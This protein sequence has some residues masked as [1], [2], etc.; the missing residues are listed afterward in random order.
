[1]C[2]ERAP[3]SRECMAPP[4]QQAPRLATR[5]M[6]ER[7]GTG[8]QTSPSHSRQRVPQCPAAHSAQLQRLGPREA[9]YAPDRLGVLNAVCALTRRLHARP[10][11]RRESASRSRRMPGQRDRLSGMA[12]GNARSHAE[13]RCVREHR[14]RLPEPSRSK[15]PVSTPTRACSNEQ[16]MNG[17][18]TWS[19][20]SPTRP[21]SARWRTNRNGTRRSAAC[22][23]CVPIS[24]VGHDHRALKL[25]E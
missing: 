15:H 2:T 18:S 6:C 24:R 13:I 5:P 4:C 22:P 8:A 21:A 16:R 20:S 23:R 25:I 3:R 10:A 19:T 12:Y 17:S 9:E 14:L 1:M 7:K 11:S